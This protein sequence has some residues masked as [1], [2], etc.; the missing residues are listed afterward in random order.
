MALLESKCG[1]RF[2]DEGDHPNCKPT[3]GALT[4]IKEELKK[5]Q[6][7]A[8][9]MMQRKGKYRVVSEGGGAVCAIFV[10]DS[11]R[12]GKSGK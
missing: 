1:M 10:P 9:R 2:L 3:V 12:K 11:K 6:V 4:S 7:E 8:A 5:K